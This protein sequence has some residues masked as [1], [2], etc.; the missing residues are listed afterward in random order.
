LS[1]LGIVFFVAKVPETRERTL[2]Q[3]ERDL[4]GEDPRESRDTVQHHA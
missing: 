2:E 3:I 4:S 1:V